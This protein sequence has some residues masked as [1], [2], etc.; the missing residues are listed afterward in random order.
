MKTK[1]IFLISLILVVG[2]FSGC[3]SVTQKGSLEGEVWG[4]SGP[5]AGAVVEGGGSTSI[6]NEEGKFLIEGLPSGETY[7]FFSCLGYTGKAIKV[8]VKAG[9]TGKINQEGRIYL[10]PQDEESLKDYIFELYSLGFYE[11]AI[12]QVDLFLTDYPEGNSLPQVLFIKGASLYHLKNFQDAISLLSHIR[13]N[14]PDN[15]FSD[16]AQYLLAKSFGEGLKNYENAIVEYQRLIDSYPDSE[17]LGIA[18][19][20]MGD[21]YYILGS[22]SEAYLSYQKAQTYG[23]EVEKGALYS[24]AHCLYKLELYPQ[25]ALLFSEYVERYPQTDISDDAQYFA[26]AAWYKAEEYSQA[27]VA[28]Q[29]CVNNYPQGTWYNGILIAPAALLNQGLCLEKLG[30]YREAYNIYLQI[31]REYPGAKWADG[32]S[33]IKNVQFRI[34]WLENNVL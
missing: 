26:G 3:F 4:E 21:C 16:D 25:A 22:Y 11:R 33:L 13:D 28:F 2:V 18:Y 27:L 7:L 29:H 9:E 24:S 23:G 34:E 19:Y 15:E 5:L 10:V 1:V 32:S 14:Y 12:S 31:I 8:E 6:T 30:R 17:F 20:E